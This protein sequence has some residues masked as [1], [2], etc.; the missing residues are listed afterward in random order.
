MVLLQVP[1]GPELLVVLLMLGFFGA[2]V[3]VA[4]LVAV[5]LLRRGSEP[6]PESS[7]TESNVDDRSN[8][9]LRREID[10]QRQRIEE[11]ESELDRQNGSEER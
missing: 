2:F 3:G 7:S 9:E 4:V 8:A 10:A 1:G 6:R 11:L 5:Y